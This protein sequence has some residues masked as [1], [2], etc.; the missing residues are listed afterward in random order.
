MI[1]VADEVLGEAIRAF[2]VLDEGA[3]L[4]EQEIIAACRTRLENFMVPQG[5]EFRD[6]L[7]TTATGKV[8]RKSL[9]E[10]SEV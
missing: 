1:G 5:V 7:P 10:P 8:R 2:V 6:S 9:K 3:T 4:T